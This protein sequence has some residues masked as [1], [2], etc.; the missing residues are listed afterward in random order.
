MARCRL[1]AARPPKKADTSYENQEYPSSYVL[2][3]T[4]LL[5][6]IRTLRRGYHALSLDEQHSLACASVWDHRPWNPT[7]NSQKRRVWAQL[8]RAGGRRIIQPHGCCRNIVQQ[9]NDHKY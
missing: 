6:E 9:R 4:V 3:G 1:H 2:C 5:T 7:R 8:S